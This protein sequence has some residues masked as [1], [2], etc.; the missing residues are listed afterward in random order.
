MDILYRR[1]RA[2]VAEILEE[3]PDPPSYSAVR[4]MLR[5]LEDKK[6]IRHEEK[7]LRYVYLPVVP[8]ERARRSAATHLLKTF[9]DNSTEQAVATLL[10]VSAHDLTPEDFDRL[11][12]LIEQARREGR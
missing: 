11:T 6:H 5:V 10:N 12:E 3:I 9:F 4:A 1:G 7:N 8:L 2:T